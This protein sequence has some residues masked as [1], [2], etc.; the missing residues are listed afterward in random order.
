MSSS[1]AARF[2]HC[3]S[4]INGEVPRQS[5]KRV[6]LS[7]AS[8]NSDALAHVPCGD[9]V[10]GMATAMYGHA[11]LMS[12]V[13]CWAN[14]FVELQALAKTYLSASL[15]QGDSSDRL[16]TASHKQ[17]GSIKSCLRCKT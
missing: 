14:L 3:H 7:G 1:S 9:D 15:N 4:N 13:C 8:L 16:R 17:H 6:T 12:G 11:I 10:Q 2:C 5:Q